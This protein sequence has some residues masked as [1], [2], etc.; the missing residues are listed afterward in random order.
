M[1]KA[2]FQSMPPVISYYGGK[3]K[4]ANKI[5]PLIPRHTVY[6]EPFAGGAA[7]L[8]KKP[9][10]DVVNKSLYREC[11]ND[12]DGHLVNFYKMLRD[13]GPE[14]VEKI[15]LTLYSREEYHDSLREGLN[16]DDP[17]ERARR[18]YA[19]IQMSFSNK[20]NAGWGTNIFSY[21][22]AA[23][24]ASKISSLPKYLERMASVSIESDDAVGVIQRWDSPQTFFY[25]DPPYPG[26]NQGHYGGYTMENFSTL[27]DALD[28]CTGSFLLSCYDVPSVTIPDNWE[29]FEFEAHCSSSGSGQ[30]GKGRDKARKATGDELG[31]RKRT[32]IVYRRF[33]RVP[34][35]SEIQKLYDSGAFDCFAFPDS[36]KPKPKEDEQ[37]LL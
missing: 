29:K 27:V 8:F 2:P 18:Y 26:A 9:W 5:I 13:H 16:C 34:V 28:N 10:P 3:Q 35:R 19:N 21:N 1:M 25:C 36:E 31:S 7:I 37:R 22:P 32:E 14:L 6:V 17:I 20:L 30:V 11:I 15:Q 4:L 23:T 33:N 12:K 24:W